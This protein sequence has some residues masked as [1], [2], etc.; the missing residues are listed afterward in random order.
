MPRPDS[1]NEEVCFTA[2]LRWSPCLVQDV[3]VHLASEKGCSKGWTVS[4]L[5]PGEPLEPRICSPIYF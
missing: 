2:L 3:V 4:S 5:H 1:K